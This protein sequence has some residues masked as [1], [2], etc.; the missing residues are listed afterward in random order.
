MVVGMAMAVGRAMAV[1]V[2]A[3]DAAREAVIVVMGL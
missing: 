2:A 3:R 1:G